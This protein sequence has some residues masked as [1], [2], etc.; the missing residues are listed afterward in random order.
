MKAGCVSP[1][2]RREADTLIPRVESVR[3]QYAK[4]LAAQQH[5]L[6]AICRAVGWRFAVHRTDHPPEAAL[7][8]LYTALAPAARRR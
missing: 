1:A 3:D 8:A 2:W 5:G 6:A 7:L 4:R